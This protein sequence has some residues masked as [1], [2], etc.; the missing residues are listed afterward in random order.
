MQRRTLLK[1]AVALSASLALSRKALFAAAADSRIEVLL[2]EP[3]GTISPA[4]YGHFTEML[5][6]VVYDGIWVGENS[7]IPNNGGIRK[8]VIEKLRQIKAPMARWPGGCFADS[9][10]WTDGIGPVAKRPERGGFW[11]GEPNAF[12]TPEFMRF[13]RLT[14]AEP[15]FAANVR[16]LSPRR[17]ITGSSTATPLLKKV[18]SAACVPTTALA[19]PTM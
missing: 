3:L 1:G 14:G 2:D 8:T 17:S 4:V 9:Y 19:N 12:G 18:L 15:Y 5:G 10:D 6:A 7:K 11:R 16:S 13:C